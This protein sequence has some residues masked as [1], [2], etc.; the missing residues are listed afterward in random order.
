MDRAAT[1]PSGVNVER[2]SVV[3]MEIKDSSLTQPRPT[4]GEAF[5]QS[6]RQ[7]VNVGGG[8]QNHPVATAR[9]SAQC[10][11][12]HFNPKW[13]ET[14]GPEG[15]KCSVQ[16]I[17]KIIHGEHAYPT[18]SEAKQ[19]VAEKALVYVHHLPC[20]DPAQKAAEKIALSEHT[21]RHC[22]RNRQGRTQIK[23]EPTA[24][25]GLTNFHRRHAYPPPA[26]PNT[27][28]YAWNAYNY[29]DQG[30][31]LHRVQSIFG[32]G[33]PSP[34]VLSDPLAAQ[35]F[36]QGLALGTSAR[37]VGPTYDP[38]LEPQGRPLPPIS[39]EVYRP[40][41][42]REQSPQRNFSRSYRDRSPLRRRTP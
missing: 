14:S 8:A 2:P 11:V 9:L 1:E 32:A 19:A 34:A 21:D 22:D 15:F 6:H 16:L 31:F 12:R 25:G 27:P 41:D 4:N 33:G 3:K 20:E 37:A 38:H 36:L 23:R 30:A 40:Y 29:N 10:Q 35:A 18:P 39:G 28:V 26:G 13:Y 24:T 5:S 42:A 7:P 17:N